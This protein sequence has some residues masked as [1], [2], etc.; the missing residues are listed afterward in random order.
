MTHYEQHHLTVDRDG[1][2]FI[3]RQLDHSGNEASVAMHLSQV[4]HLAEKAGVTSGAGYQQERALL[5]LWGKLFLLTADCYL[6]EIVERCGG[7][8]TYQAHALDAR[9]ILA[10]ILED[11]G[12]EVPTFEDEEAARASNEK[13]PSPRNDKSGEGISV[14]PSQ[15]RGRPST[16]TALS[17]AERQAKHRA[18]QA[19]LLP[20]TTVAN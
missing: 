5:R 9:N 15:G 14:T 4:A 2:D 3:L 19:E 12:I 1:D 6:D 8:L 11:L 20:V 13:S 16:G 10:D 18:R 7:G 17:N